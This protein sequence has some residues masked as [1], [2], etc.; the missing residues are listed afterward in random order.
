MGPRAYPVGML[1]RVRVMSVGLL[2][3]G[4]VY[5]LVMPSEHTNLAKAAMVAGCILGIF[6]LLRWTPPD[7]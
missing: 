5:I 4:V 3:F 7:L 2:A 6:A 1:Q